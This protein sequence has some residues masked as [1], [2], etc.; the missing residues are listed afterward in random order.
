M[1]NDILL[2]E[3]IYQL[4]KGHIECGILPA[5]AKLPSRVELCKEFQVSEKTVR[6]VLELLAEKGLIETQQRKRPV[7]NAPAAGGAAVAALLPAVPKDVFDTGRLLCYPVIERGVALC[8]QEDWA[9]PAAVLARMDPAHGAP[10]WR[11]SHRFWRFFIA[12]NGNDLILRAVDSLG[13]FN[14]EPLPGTLALREGYLRSLQSFMGAAAQGGG[15]ERPLFE[16]LSQLYG[17]G[18]KRAQFESRYRTPP[19]SPPRAGLMGLEQRLR[20]AEERYSH[21]YMDMLGLIAIGRYLPGDR[22]PS[23]KELQRLYDVSG[24]TTAKAVQ[25]LQEWGVV[26]AKR[27][28]GIYV[29]MDLAGLKNVQIDPGLLGC[30]LRRFLDSLELLSLT[31]EGV[32]AHAAAAIPAE[33]AKAFLQKMDRLWNAAYLYQLTPMVLLE[34]ITGY[35]QY[36]S[37]KEVYQV[38]AKN[39]H[40][41]RCIPRLVTQDK[42][43]QSRAIHAQGTEAVEC[44]LRGDA[45]GFA[46]KA[47]AMF[48]YVHGLVA[49][50][51]KSL[52]YWEAARK[53]YD[54]TALWKK[55]NFIAKDEA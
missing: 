20:S 1:K 9:I 55:T 52:G 37:L 21:V 36:P 25:T 31:A 10:F 26:T 51:C 16:C 19:G 34:F 42:T 22:L 5:G 15:A 47:S 41:G 18:G 3:R 2:Y 44:L 33:A 23:H 53:V 45:A 32:A 40:I 30:H 38:V 27:G 28:R 7:V 12:R 29:A 6:R 24:D 49:Q 39:Y 54:G 35:I 50:A 43:A 8:A 17:P 13:F 11:L 14:L 48:R 4:L 46:Q